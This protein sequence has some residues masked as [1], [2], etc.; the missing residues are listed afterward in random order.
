MKSVESL[1]S[2]MGVFLLIIGF[3]FLVPLIALFHIYMIPDLWKL[4][5][6]T[7]G[8]SFMIIAWIIIA[9]VLVAVI[10]AYGIEII[11]YHDKKS[12]IKSIDENA[13]KSKFRPKEEPES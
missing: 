6:E 7:T 9:V 1:P 10:F 3:T 5:I 13:E 4:V 12:D 2:W 8:W 11:W